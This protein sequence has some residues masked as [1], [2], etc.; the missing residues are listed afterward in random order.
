MEQLHTLSNLELLHL[1]QRA[2]QA[3]VSGN[4]DAIKTTMI[5]LEHHRRT[6]Q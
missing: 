1:E 6:H 3:V 4:P 2:A 5:A